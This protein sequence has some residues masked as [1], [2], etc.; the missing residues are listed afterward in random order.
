MRTKWFVAMLLL[1]GASLFGQTVG[2]ITGQVG[3]PSGAGVPAAV[4]TLTNT[5]TNAVR[6][7]TSSDQGLY[8]FTSVPPGIYNI[9]V[10]HP[11]FKTTTSN[12]VQVQVQQ[13]VRL[14]LTLQVGQVSES[15]EVSAA[16]DLLQA[17]NATVGTVV[18]TQSIT[19]LPLNGREYLNLVALS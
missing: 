19:Q 12:N 2:E 16:A 7:A 17:E 18:E 14:D 9:K 1:A 10:E 15:V 5:T 4:L 8:T 6:Q 13:S 11:G 3:D